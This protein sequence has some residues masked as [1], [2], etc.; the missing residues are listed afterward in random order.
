MFRYLHKITCKNMP[1]INQNIFD[2]LA[3]QYIRNLASFL[4][5]TSWALQIFWK[6]P[7]R[8]KTANSAKWSC[9]YTRVP[10]GESCSVRIEMV[11]LTFILS[12][13][14]SD[15]LKR[16]IIVYFYPIF[17]CGL[18]CWAVDITNPTAGYNGTIF[19]KF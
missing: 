2:G 8:Q 12:V 6:K 7:M 16:A 14:D 19:R 18:N 5:A 10:F 4:C 9:H 13:Y 3:F 15:T 17:Q 1:Q 11:I